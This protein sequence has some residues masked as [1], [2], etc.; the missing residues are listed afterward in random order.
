MRA[1]PLAVTVLALAALSNEHVARADDPS[2]LEC[3]TASNTSVK[4][5]SDHKLQMARAQLVVCASPSCPSEVREECAQ[6]M[7]RWAAQMPSVVFEVKD[8]AG[9]E[10]SAVKVTV[11]GGALT[12][13]LDGT[14]IELDPGTHRF[15][16]E[17]AG[18][19]TVVEEYILHEGEKDRR[20]TVVVGDAA[21]PVAGDASAAPLAPAESVPA[22]PPPERPKMTNSG[23]NMRMA[24]FIVG[25][26][27]L[28]GL[29]ASGVLGVAAEL[30]WNDVTPNCRTSGSCNGHDH[31]NS[32][33]ASNLANAATVALISG[34]VLAAAG[35][36]LYFVAPRGPRVG[37]LVS[38]DGMAITG[39]F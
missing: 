17:A 29:L 36:A 3:L 21:P 23:G 8:G 5:R 31:D 19:P 15:T 33:E 38:P 12:E 28:A 4:L 22:P 30:K 32:V 9:H 13:R 10:L 26:T 2:V 11:D 18:Q 25:G 14:A 34:G 7:G 1:I 37:V 35:L 39:A 6:R 20:E 27:G 24:G 16:F